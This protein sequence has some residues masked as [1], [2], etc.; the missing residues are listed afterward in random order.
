MQHYIF[1]IW[2]HDVRLSGGAKR[3]H[4]LY[5]STHPGAKVKYGFVTFFAM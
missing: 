1:T 3:R 5:T 4:L 2:H